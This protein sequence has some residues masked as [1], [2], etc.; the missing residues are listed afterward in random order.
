MKLNEKDSIWVTSWASY[1][2]G[3]SKGGWFNLDELSD[4]TNDEIFDE[5]RKIGLDPD[6]F[7]EELVVHDYDNYTGLP[8]YELFGEPHPITVINFYRKLREA[9]FKIKDAT[10]TFM[11]IYETESTEEALQALQDDELDSWIIMDEDTL[12]ENLK[13]LL[14]FYD[15]DRT[16]ISS[17]IDEDKI[18]ESFDFAVY[19]DDEEDICEEDI[20]FYIE[21]FIENCSIKEL[22]DSYIDIEHYKSNILM[23]GSIAEFTVDGEDYYISKY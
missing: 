12:N 11:G 10:L 23:D 5:F 13:E 21:D 6:G 17:Y 14:M 2:S 19:D 22:I 8:Y 9:S 18:K 15:K 4:L 7:D 3:Y 1:N 20:E 16:K